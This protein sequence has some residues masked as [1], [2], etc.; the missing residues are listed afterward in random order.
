LHH[1]A[2]QPRAP[3]TAANLTLTAINRKI[4]LKISQFSIRLSEITQTRATRLNGLM[5]HLANHRHKRCDAR[6]R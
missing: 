3:I 2:D 5:Q 1:T 6:L 4:M